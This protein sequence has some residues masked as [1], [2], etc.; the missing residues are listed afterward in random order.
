MKYTYNKRTDRLTKRHTNRLA[1]PPP[2]PPARPPRRPRRQSHK[3]RPQHL[4]R[5]FP[6]L[7]RDRQG[8]RGRQ[9]LGRDRGYGRGSRELAA[10]GYR[11]GEGRRGSRARCAFG[12]AA[13]G[14]RE[15]CACW[16]GGWV[17]GWKGRFWRGGHGVRVIGRTE[18]MWKSKLLLFWFYWSLWKNHARIVS[19]G[20]DR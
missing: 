15:A 19:L 13:S 4:L 12:R 5:P 17:G 8:G 20:I 6:R 18:R 16:V 14:A 9:P 10:S 2:L 3:P 1:R 11:G 7:R